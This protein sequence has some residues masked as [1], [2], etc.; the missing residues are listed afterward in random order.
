MRI[1]SPA[2]RLDRLGR[3]PTHQCRPPVLGLAARTPPPKQSPTWRRGATRRPERH[4]RA[5]RRHFE[6]TASSTRL[7]R[8]QRE[9][10]CDADRCKAIETFGTSLAAPAS[11]WLSPAQRRHTGR[12]ATERDELIAAGPIAA[13]ITTMRAALAAADRGVRPAWSCCPLGARPGER[14][15]SSPVIAA[16][17]AKG[18]SGYIAM[19]QPLAAS[20]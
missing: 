5:A 15:A 20:M 7:R 3:A 18:V 17:R 10:G 6:A 12:S 9:R 8:A 2:L 13:R 14:Q 4:R 16:A 1:L 11:P 19:D